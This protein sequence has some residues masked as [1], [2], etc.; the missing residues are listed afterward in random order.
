MTKWANNFEER[1]SQVKAIF[2]ELGFEFPQ[3]T[4]QLK[5]W[6]NAF[7][8]YPIQVDE[9][10]IDP[11]KILRDIKAEKVCL[12][13][14]PD[15]DELLAPFT[16]TLKGEWVYVECYPTGKPIKRIRSWQIG[17]KPRCRFRFG[18]KR[19]ELIEVSL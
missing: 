5:A 15:Y 13:R 11:K 16:Q 18:I 2:K 4:E 7:K 17:L 10:C 6:D 1:S 8:D 9:K 12:Y 19:E 14:H 3:N